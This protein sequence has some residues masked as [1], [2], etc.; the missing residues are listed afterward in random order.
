MKPSTDTSGSNALFEKGDSAK[1]IG[2]ITGYESDKIVS[3]RHLKVGT[4]YTVE[5]YQ[6]DGTFRNVWLEGF[7]HVRFN[8]TEFVKVAN[9]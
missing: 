7:P 5:R 8:A 6:F 9:G 4:I 2:V 3:Q 1:F